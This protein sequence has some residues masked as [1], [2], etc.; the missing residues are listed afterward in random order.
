MLGDVEKI[1]DNAREKGVGKIV[2]AGT[3]VKT[4]RFALEKSEKYEEI[5]CVLGIYPDD[6]LK[7]TDSDIDKEIEFIR[8]NREKI[9]GIG[10][11]GMDFKNT[12]DEK[13]RKR[14]EEIFRKFVSL[15]LDLNVPLIIHSREAERECV[16]ILESMGAKKVVM[17][18]FFGDMDLV[19]KIMKNG[20][21]LSIPTCCVKTDWFWGVI[22]F[23]D[24]SLLL[25]ETDSPYMHP[26]GRKA[27]KKNEPANVVASY[28]K[29][30]EIK[31]LDLRDV[32]KVIEGNYKALFGI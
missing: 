3:D 14:R 10:E 22:D 7:M 31:K 17:H 27:R 28:G 16:G 32:E 21:S 15:A 12:L 5:E 18:S 8:E 30:S 29:I 23:V 2:A 9:L 11:V 4:N 26:E 24:L 25:C 20:W 13:G 1:I 19:K 6:A